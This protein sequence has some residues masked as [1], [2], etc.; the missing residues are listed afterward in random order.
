MKCVPVSTAVCLWLFDSKGICPP[1]NF[2]RENQRRKVYIEKEKDFR[3]SSLSSLL[4]KRERV[5]RCL[6]PT[7]LRPTAQSGSTVASYHTAAA[8][9]GRQGGGAG[10]RVSFAGLQPGLSEG[11]QQQA[12]LPLG[13]TRASC[14]TRHQPTQGPT[15][16]SVI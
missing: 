9:L 8:A 7:F 4:A 2:A 11:S 10:S 5:E 6:M 13:K 3:S 12:G 15:A 14:T 16:A 1:N